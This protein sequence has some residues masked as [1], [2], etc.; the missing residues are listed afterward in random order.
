MLGR[1]V[2]VF[3]SIANTLAQQVAM[4][5]QQTGHRRVALTVSD[6]CFSPASAPLPDP[7]ARISLSRLTVQ[8]L[9]AERYGF[10][11]AQLDA[12]GAD[13]PVSSTESRIAL[14]VQ[15]AIE[16]AINQ[17]LACN[18]TPKPS[19]SQPWQWEASIQ[20]GTYPRQK[21]HITLPTSSS[22]CLEHLAAIQ[23]AP[24]RATPAST[25]PLVIELHA[26]LAQKNMT[27]AQIQE[28]RVGS[29]IAIAMERA[30]VCLNGQ[31]MLSASV[32]EHQ[33]KLH[34]T[35]FENLD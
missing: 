27:A 17:T 25:E 2:Q 18:R 20:V 21:L 16:D 12:S 10:A 30:Q 19:S 26:V 1:P 13:T 11:A 8:A 4:H 35:A 23:R 3:A 15:A 9:M 14:S 33:G 34:L 7:R 29:T 28:L 31:T 32:A 24:I 22:D 6:A 5:I